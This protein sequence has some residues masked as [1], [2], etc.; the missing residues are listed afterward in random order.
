MVASAT[1]NVI[2]C[3]FVRWE[4]MALQFMKGQFDVEGITVG[5][6]TQLDIRVVV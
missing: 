1:A 2:V 4:V 5:I 3:V 6:A